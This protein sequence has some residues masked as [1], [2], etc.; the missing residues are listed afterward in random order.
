MGPTGA[1]SIFK[2]RIH[3]A[4]TGLPRVIVYIEDIII[5]G[6][7]QEEYDCNLRNIL[8]LLDEFNFRPRRV[9]FLLHLFRR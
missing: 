7:Y 5:F 9:P 8:C 1:V 4:L 6:A 2:R 3:H